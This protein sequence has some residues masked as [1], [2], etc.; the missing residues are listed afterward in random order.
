MKKICNILIGYIWMV[1]MKLF[2]KYFQ[3]YAEYCLRTTF[4]EEE[5]IEIFAKE[6]PSC[7]DI[8]KLFKIFIGKKERFYRTGMPLTLR[9][10]SYDQNSLRSTV[11]IKC[12]SAEHSCETILHITLAP[13]SSLV[14]PFIFVFL[15]FDLLF[16]SLA[17]CAG[18]WQG[19]LGL[20]MPLFLFMLLAACRSAEESR[21]PEIC[22]EFENTL[23]KLENKYRGQTFLIQPI[24]QK[25]KKLNF[26]LITPLLIIPVVLVLIFDP[27]STLSI[28]NFFDDIF[29]TIFFIDFPIGM[30]LLHYYF[31]QFFLHR[32]SGRY[33]IVPW[34]IFF[35]VCWGLVALGM[36]LET[37]FGRYPE[38]G[39]SVVCAY[40][41][42]WAYI[43]FT[44][45]PIGLFYLLIRGIQKL[46]NKRGVR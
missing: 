33:S 39:F 11:F 5:L 26:V 31:P 29:G 3:P 27:A 23:H 18:V 34:G 42:G 4:S 10:Y 16:I 2:D 36:F 30:C 41:F 32:K 46:W 13:D 15:G 24:N 35:L 19:I 7:C 6:F 28:R 1:K 40:L 22:Q 38:N 45:I 20:I 12:S 25:R 9:T 43:W 8:C 17:L 21:I 14:K 37:Q 44:M